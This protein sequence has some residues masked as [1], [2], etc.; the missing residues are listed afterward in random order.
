M[1]T[2]QTLADGSRAKRMRCPSCSPVGAKAYFSPSP[3]GG[4]E[5]RCCGAFRPATR[6][7]NAQAAQKAEK[8][9]QPTTTP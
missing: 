1:T 5:C 8:A 7:E 9:N 4:W 6:S 2:Y 3:T